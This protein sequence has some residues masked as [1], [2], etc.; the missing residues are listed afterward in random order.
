MID[1]DI[2]GDT[3]VKNLHTWLP[4]GKKYVCHKTLTDWN[5]KQ[6]QLFAVRIESSSVDGLNIYPVRGSYM[7]KYKNSLI[8][9]HFRALQKV[10]MF[11]LY[12]ELESNTHLNLWRTTEELGALMY[13]GCIENVNEYLVIPS[14]QIKR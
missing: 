13:Y 3:P 12:G 1:L 14:R 5:G 11:H 10:G 2:H 9:K 8:G 6:E 7:V 4:G